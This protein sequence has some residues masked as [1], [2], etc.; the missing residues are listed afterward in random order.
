MDFLMGAR[1]RDF[2]MVCCDTSANM[3]IINLK[4]DEDKILP[5][6]SHRVM[7]LGGEAGDRIYFAQYIILNV[8]LYGLRNSTPLS[9]HAIANF[10]RMELANS[11]R[12]AP[13][14]ANLLIA[15][16][17]EKKGPSLY[18]LDYLATMHTT[19]YAGFGY[20]WYFATSIFDRYWR[21]DIGEDEAM[22][23]MDKAIAEVNK[24]L[25]IASGKYVIKIVDKNGIRVAKTYK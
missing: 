15:G 22:E 8:K 12:K 3:S 14:M 19:T 4:D 20:G 21:S 5:I 23:V 17:D 7:A 16:Y 9:T 6:D 10:A 1:G 18:W 13:Y 24:R 11:L 2:V 25:I